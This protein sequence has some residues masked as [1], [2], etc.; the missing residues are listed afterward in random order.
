MPSFS[1][2]VTYWTVDLRGIQFQSS[3][4]VKH[5][6]ELTYYGTWTLTLA[7]TA[8]VTGQSETLLD[9]FLK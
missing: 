5:M 2:N 7:F 3:V 9:W 1:L 6:A 8:V 4:Y